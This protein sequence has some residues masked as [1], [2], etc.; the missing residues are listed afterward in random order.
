MAAAGCFGGFGGMGSIFGGGAA[1]GAPMASA[2][3]QQANAMNWAM[4]P[5][6]FGGFY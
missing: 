2:G 6:S 5:Q 4:N 3:M 1:A